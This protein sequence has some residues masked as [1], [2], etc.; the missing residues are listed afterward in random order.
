MCLIPIGATLKIMNVPTALRLASIVA[1]SV[2]HWDLEGGGINYEARWCFIQGTA[3][4]FFKGQCY[5][6]HTAV[7]ES[8]FFNYLLL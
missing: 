2:G 7:Q 4:I 8:L 6:T 5:Q 1:L 3:V